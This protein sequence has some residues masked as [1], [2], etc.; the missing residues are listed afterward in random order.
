MGKYFENLEE[1]FSA[2]PSVS[3]LSVSSDEKNLLVVAYVPGLTV[4]EIDVS[5][6]DE[7]VH[8]IK[9][10]RIAREKIRKTTRKAH[11]IFSLL[12]TAW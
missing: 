3:G 5:I 1:E 6:D 7:G 9:G 12:R 11:Q 10:E 2:L 4:N 8:W